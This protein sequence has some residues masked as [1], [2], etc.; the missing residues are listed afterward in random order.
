M[1]N[2]YF[3]FCVDW[4]GQCKLRSEQKGFQVLLTK[5]ADRTISYLPPYIMYMSRSL[6]MLP[7]QNKSTL[8]IGHQLIITSNGRRHHMLYIAVVKIPFQSIV[9]VMFYYCHVKLYEK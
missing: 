4:P 6:F 3:L 5:G 1:T 9:Q 2:I 8:G 7:Y